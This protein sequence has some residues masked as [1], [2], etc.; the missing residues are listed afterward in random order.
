M[1]RQNRS[2]YLVLRS[3]FSSIDILRLF[4]H[5]ACS[6]IQ[7]L[8]HF[9]LC[10]LLLASVWQIK[11]LVNSNSAHLCI[12]WGSIFYFGYY[13]E[14]FLLSM[15]FRIDD[16]SWLLQQVHLCHFVLQI[17]W[18]IQ[19]RRGKSSSNSIISFSVS[20]SL[21]YQKWW[22]NEDIQ[23]EQTWKNVPNTFFVID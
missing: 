3:H 21:I 7:W 20:L 6:A 19:L 14:E 12:T 15:A 2:F 11:A 4:L 9:I 17:D 10:A 8:D 5:F 16:S 22:K 13:L 23:C 1:S 18:Q